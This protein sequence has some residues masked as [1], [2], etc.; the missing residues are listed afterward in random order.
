MGSRQAV[1]FLFAAWAT[2]SAWLDSA[3]SRLKLAAWI[4]FI[5][6]SQTLAAFFR[7]ASLPCLNCFR[8]ARAASLLTDSGFSERLILSH[9]AYMAPK[10]GSGWVQRSS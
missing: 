9:T 4:F 1:I 6:K 3:C 7:S 10:E 5:M 2:L 8:I